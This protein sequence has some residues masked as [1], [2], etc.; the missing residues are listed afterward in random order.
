ME[1]P[2][3]IY[4]FLWYNIAQL[5]ESGT[6]MIELGTGTV[7]I[8]Y[9]D[10]TSAAFDPDG[11]R[12]RLEKGFSDSGCADIWIAGEIVL[13]VNT[14]SAA[15]RRNPAAPI[16]SYTP[17]TLTT[18]SPGFWKTPGTLPWLSISRAVLRRP[19]ISEKSSPDRWNSI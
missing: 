4:S 2:F 10:G 11:L 3:A 15:G 16:M 8:L 9:S 5:K 17:E 7:S 19:G 14:P 18:A 6:D 13:A 1:N 12:V